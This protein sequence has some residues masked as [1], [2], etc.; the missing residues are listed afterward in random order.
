MNIT[1]RS[2]VKGIAA[3]LAV[4]AS[5]LNTSLEPRAELRRLVDSGA[6]SNPPT[7]FETRYTH[8]TIAMGFTITEEL[9]DDNLYL[10]ISDRQAKALAKALSRSVFN[11]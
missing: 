11:G 9:V 10:E 8:K 3:I 5:V 4:P 1:R 6:L 7:G 2:L